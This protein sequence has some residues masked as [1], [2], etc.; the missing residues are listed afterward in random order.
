MSEKPTPFI[1][2]ITKGILRDRQMRRTVLFWIVVATLALLGVGA[3]L[4]DAWLSQ[5]IILFLLYWGACLWLTA[6]SLLL[7]LYDL[8]AIRAEA[9]RERQRLKGRVFGEDTEDRPL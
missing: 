1:L 7:A 9:A 3:L 2:L 5:H 8:L 4:L 6:T